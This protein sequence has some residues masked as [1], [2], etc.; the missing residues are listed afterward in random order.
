MKA[1]DH[2]VALGLGHQQAK[3]VSQA[4][5]GFSN[6][7]RSALINGV[8][9]FRLRLVT[10]SSLHSLIAPLDV[11]NV[12]MREAQREVLHLLSGSCEDAGLQADVI[13]ELLNVAVLCLN[14]GAGMQ[15]EQSQRCWTACDPNGLAASQEHQ[16]MTPDVYDVYDEADSFEGD[17]NSYHSG[18]LS[19]EMAAELS[20]QS[21]IAI[22]MGCSCSRNALTEAAESSCSM[23]TWP[24]S[25]GA[26][27]R[28]ESAYGLYN[29]NT[30]D[31][32]YERLGSWE[33]LSAAVEGMYT[34]LRDDPC[35]TRFFQGYDTQQ[36]MR[37]MTGFISAAVGGDGTYTGEELWRIHCP[38]IQHQGLGME[39]VDLMCEHL[40]EV[41]AGIGLSASMVKETV[42]SLKS[43]R[44]VFASN[45][46]PG[47]SPTNSGQAPSVTPAD[48]ASTSKSGQVHAASAVNWMDAAAADSSL[49]PQ[50]AHQRSHGS[51]AML[52]GAVATEK[53]AAAAAAAYGDANIYTAGYSQHKGAKAGEHA[54]AVAGT[55]AVGTHTLALDELR[56]AQRRSTDYAPGAPACHD[57][58]ASAVQKPVSNNCVEAQDL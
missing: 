25:S 51:P 20:E 13:S 11:G 10:N 30:S 29:R 33:V 49:A 16:E 5:L 42:E 40:Q 52:A 39:H 55:P 58:V 50:Q 35:T 36:I 44:W 8:G 1:A 19:V 32:L 22:A 14:L 12:A 41:L 9:S 21:D 15:R 2:A 18:I 45:N 38:L 53:S 3:H 54:A 23:S 43:M 26:S 6:T 37:H 7:L 17:S 31:S 28:K 47:K 24:G 56:Q 46:C 57:S 4:E 27:L 48:P 34:R